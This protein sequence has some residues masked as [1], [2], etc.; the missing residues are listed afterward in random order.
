[1]ISG[2]GAV[3]IDSAACSTQPGWG[4]RAARC[5]EAELSGKHEEA[6]AAVIHPSEMFSFLTFAQKRFGFDGK[7]SKP[8]V[9]L[10]RLTQRRR[11]RWDSEAPDSNTLR[12][13][14]FPRHFAVWPAVF[15]P[16]LS[17]YVIKLHLDSKRHTR[18]S[19]FMLSMLPLTKHAPTKY[20]SYALRALC[21]R[22]FPACF[23]LLLLCHLHA[24]IHA[25]T[26]TPQLMRKQ[27][28]NA[29]FNLLMDPRKWR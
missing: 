7:A 21:E 28:R 10:L 27:T 25:V 8:L 3:C 9:F 12:G 18:C 2:L 1:M 16:V 17:V 4:S 14:F 5:G 26:N 6:W 24:H 15:G 19:L 13:C 23:P 29:R 22:G 11:T 20:C